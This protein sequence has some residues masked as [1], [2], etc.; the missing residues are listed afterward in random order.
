VSESTNEWE[1]QGHTLTWINAFISSHPIGLDT[2]TQEFKNADGKRSDVTVW[3]DHAS[4]IAVFTIELK[5]PKTTLADVTFQS[6]AVRKAQ[7]LKSPYLA[8][9]NMQT[10]ALY[11]TPA[12]PRK[13]LLPYDLI[14]TWEPDPLVKSVSDWLNPGTKDSLRHRAQDLM[15]EVNDLLTSGSLHRIVVD[16][17][18]FVSA[19]TERIRLLRLQIEADVRSSLG[20]SAKLR[21]TI[22]AWALKQG[23]RTQVGDMYSALAGQVAYRIVGQTLFYLSF[24]RQQPSLPSM[25]LDD[26]QPL[27]V[28]LR[29]CWD[30]IRAYDYEALFEES[31][32]ETIPLTADTE[33]SLI[34]LIRDLGEYD[35]N[36]VE[37]D[38]LGTV[39]EH[40]I[41][42]D[43]RI[44]LGQF[45]TTNDLADLIIS[46]TVDSPN[47]RVLDPALGTGTFLLRTH[48]RLS[49]TAK[50]THSEILDRLW[51]VDISAFAAELAVINL[52]RQDL[53]S[54]DNFPRITVRDFF[55]LKTTD[56]LT[57]PPAHFV[58]NLPQHVS[59]PIPAFDA[60][61]GNPPYVRSQ[62]L[63]DLDTAY[64]SKLAT[65]TVAAGLTA[66]PKFDAF[67]YFIVHARNFLKPGGRLG[68]VTSAAWL[69]SNY[70]NILKGYI[71]KHFQPVVLL[72]SLA[73][74][75][76]PSVAV[77][78]VV[79]ILKAKSTSSS[80]G[81][82]PM[83]FVT[84]RKPLSDLLPSDTS[85]DY[86]ETLDQFTG[87]LETL[88]IGVYEGYS[89]SEMDAESERQALLADPRSPRNWAQP[90]RS[91]P[92]YEDVFT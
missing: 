69:T 52:C 30:A 92:I 65:V 36:N 84:L 70:G 29:S 25:S 80:A 72:F 66:S 91:T 33:A 8:L 64:K 50:L 12:K 11:R 7:Q 89:I 68:F 5:T 24:R 71:L 56:S 67:A 48:N 42:G 27:H 51:G 38:V 10:L 26:T 49:R 87:D 45:Y 83:R 46:L 76:F 13:T 44:A 31:P 40:L 85:N 58:G 53:D 21:K 35:W 16:A 43:E 57:F 54:Q 18:V 62:T 15:T 81:L 79:V 2:A 22:S 3:K 9:W 78:T 74:P 75:F 61:M 6:D 39:F 1:F 41:P 90:F 77:D 14:R 73:E 4:R 19:L 47:D 63:D 32:L 37:S 59:I 17:T 88:P 86:W 55:D 60:V 23:L 28:Q 20:A 34:E 82:T